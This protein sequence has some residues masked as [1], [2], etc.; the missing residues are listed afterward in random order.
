[1]MVDERR[2]REPGRLASPSWSAVLAIRLTRWRAS[3]RPPNRRVDKPT[4]F[5]HLA[6][7]AD[8]G[9]RHDDPFLVHIKPDVGDTICQD[10]SPTHEAR[11]RPIRRN[12][13]HLHTVRQVASSSG[14]HVV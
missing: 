10:P 4:V 8:L 12:P 1:M 7:A 5:P 2:K 9:D 14:G 3:S 6:A 13:R 11:Y